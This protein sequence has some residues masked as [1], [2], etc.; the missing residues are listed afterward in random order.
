MPIGTASNMEWL[1]GTSNAQSVIRVDNI[2]S[3]TTAQTLVHTDDYDIIY[4]PVDSN[5]PLYLSS[6]TVDTACVYMREMS[7]SYNQ[8]HASTYTSQRIYGVP[9]YKQAYSG[10]DLAN[11]VEVW[12]FSSSDSMP[13]I[14]VREFTIFYTK[15]NVPHMT[16]MTLFCTWIIADRE[17]PVPDFMY[18]GISQ[19]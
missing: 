7:V 9:L 5:K 12:R 14:P 19:I 16:K 6:S 10:V 4:D 2:Y 13:S 17:K 1:V 11:P 3:M 8:D 15:D 18:A